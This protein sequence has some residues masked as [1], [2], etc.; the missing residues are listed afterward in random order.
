MAARCWLALAAR[1][2]DLRRMSPAYESRVARA[3]PLID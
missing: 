2:G 1:T 3:E